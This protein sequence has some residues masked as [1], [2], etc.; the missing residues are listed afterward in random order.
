M[1]AQTDMMKNTGATSFFM[2][3]VKPIGEAERVTLL[4][5]LQTL[6]V[7]SNK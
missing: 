7:S 1:P 5:C 4:F 2:L 3:N 6:A